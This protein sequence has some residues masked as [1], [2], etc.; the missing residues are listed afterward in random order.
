MDCLC[1]RTE[2]MLLGYCEVGHFG[3]GKTEICACDKLSCSVQTY[4]GSESQSK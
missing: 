1:G 4:C 3:G 2:D